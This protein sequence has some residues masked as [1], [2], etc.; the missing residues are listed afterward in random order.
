MLSRK[1][2]KYRGVPLK[3]SNR[4]FDNINKYQ[5]GDIIHNYKSSSAS[6]PVTIKILSKEKAEGT[7]LPDEAIYTYEVIST[8]KSNPSFMPTPEY[9]RSR[10]NSA[11]AENNPKNRPMTSKQKA[12]A[13]EGSS[14]GF[15]RN[16]Q[17]SQDA[18]DTIKAFESK[19]FRIVSTNN[20]GKTIVEHSKYGVFTISKDG[21]WWN[22]DDTITGNDNKDVIKAFKNP[23][24]PL[25]KY[26]RSRTNSAIAENAKKM[27]EKFHGRK[28]NRVIT[29]DELEKDIT[30]LAV[31]G[32]LEQLEIIP[33]DSDAQLDLNFEDQ[34]TNENDIIEVC[35]DAE[36][37]QIYLEKGDQDIDSS[38]KEIKKE[39]T[40]TLAQRF[41]ILGHILAICYFTDKWHLKEEN[42]PLW[43]VYNLHS[44]GKRELVG[45]D[46]YEE[47]AIEL[48][49]ENEELGNEVVI[50]TPY[51]HEFGEDGGEMP[52]LVYDELNKKLQIV[53]GTYVVKDVG[54]W[55]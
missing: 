6:I 45:E 27:A 7:F 37:K 43:R 8:K 25:P 34:F 5:I 30:E 28:V 26:L 38:L 31:I 13:S 46:L 12:I 44:N 47:D 33:I 41:I 23:K 14:L 10:T 4:I 18:I 3:K 24:M 17:P 42:E 15:G 55:N 21:S 20:S 16:F 39:T 1:N 53:G 50:G 48:Q 52:F 54:I 49:K 22:N 9:L 29:I 19:R 32:E 11:I 36:G 2:A 35:T 51:R 40:Q